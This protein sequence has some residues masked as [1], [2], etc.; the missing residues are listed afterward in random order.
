MKIKLGFGKSYAELEVEDRNLIGVIQPNT[1]N[2]QRV[3]HISFIK[4]RNWD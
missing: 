1:V 4:L 3:Y 2:V